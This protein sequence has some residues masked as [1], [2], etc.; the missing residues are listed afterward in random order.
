MGYVSFWEGNIFQSTLPETNVAPEIWWL[1][2]YFP[3]GKTYFQVQV[4]SF[5]EG[6][7][8]T[9]LP[10]KP[11]ALCNWSIWN[12]EDDVIG[13]RQNTWNLESESS[14]ELSITQRRFHGT[15]TP[16]HEIDFGEKNV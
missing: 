15:A 6:S 10:A 1:E 16:I 9:I 8:S 4:V 11:Q 3:F 12:C 13:G 2:D 7:F 14:L 5:R